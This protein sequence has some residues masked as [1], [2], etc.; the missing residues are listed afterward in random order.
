MVL[1]LVLF[2]LYFDNGGSGISSSVDME[3]SA[4]FGY[5][6]LAKEL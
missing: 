6:V 3:E 2:A 5:G 1:V 4:G